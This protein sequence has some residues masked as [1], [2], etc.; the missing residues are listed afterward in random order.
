MKI[1]KYNKNNIYSISFEYDKGDKC[2]CCFKRYDKKTEIAHTFNNRE[3]YE[4][5]ISMLKHEFNINL[6]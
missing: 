5:Y 2:I 1:T 4:Q 6:K 3:E